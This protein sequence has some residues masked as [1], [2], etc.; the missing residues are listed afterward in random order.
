MPFQLAVR[1]NVVYASWRGFTADELR[2]VGLR[3]SDLRHAIGR[4]V[5]YLARIPAGGGGFTP[6]EHSTLLE[7]L[8][9]I[10]PCCATIHHVLEGDGFVK[11]AR[12]ATLT[13]LANATP[14][15]R[16]FHAHEIL[17]GAFTTI[18]TMYGVDLRDFGAS[19]S[20]PPDDERASSAFRAAARIIEGRR[21]RRD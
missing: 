15:P 2:E 12:R 1:E 9:S 19:P 3:I 8:L 4:Q 16:D 21:P 13:N 18:R 11:S 10:L 20:S 17:D 7:F 14:R 5:V 6:E